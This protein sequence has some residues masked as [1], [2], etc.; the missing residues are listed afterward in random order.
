VVADALGNALP[1]VS[2]SFAAPS[3]GAS[4][5]LS[6]SSVTTD[7]LGSASV[8][9]TANGHAGSYSVTASVANVATPATFSLTNDGSSFIDVQSG[10]PQSAPPGA[11]FGQPLVVVV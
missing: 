1:N 10:T 7:S 11:A 6:A 3:T 8:T 9:A 2:V 4:A 5:G